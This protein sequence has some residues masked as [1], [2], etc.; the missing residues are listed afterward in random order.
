MLKFSADGRAS[1]PSC[2]PGE[3]A[4]LLEIAALSLEVFYFLFSSL[5]S[6]AAGAPG[7]PGARFAHRGESNQGSCL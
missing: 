6:F 1:H 3:K 7:A 4:S 5:S 2:A